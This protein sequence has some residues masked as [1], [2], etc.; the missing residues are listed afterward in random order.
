MTLNN[1]KKHWL[2]LFGLS[3]LLGPGWSLLAADVDF[4]CMD[5]T[6]RGKTPLTDRY[7]EYD[8]VLQNRC[9]GPVYWAMCI[10]RVDPVT[11]EVIE[12]HTPT[13]YIEADNRA[14]VNLQM[15]KGP[16]RMAF[17]KRY[18]EFYVG[19]GYAIKSAARA[20]CVA[21]QCAPEQR[22]L[23][24]RIDAN[25]KAWERAENALNAQLVSECPESGWDKSEEVEVC[26]ANIREAAAEELEALA[27]IDAQLRE[28]L[29]AAGPEH[30]RIQGGDLVKE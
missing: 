1:S 20:A 2:A 29:A 24:E 27:A 14:R 5:Y 4:S 6:V 22:A 11:H 26:Q 17:R 23:R 13:G 21:A 9:P 12:V 15:K 25:L 28:E 19:I 18:Q 30:C 16:E 3:L 8:V 10:E 7:K